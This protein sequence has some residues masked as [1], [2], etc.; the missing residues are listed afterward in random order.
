MLLRRREPDAE[1]EALLDRIAA[2]VSE[3]DGNSPGGAHLGPR[4]FL[5]L[6][7]TYADEERLV[8][9][10]TAMELLRRAT[11]VHRMPQL[12]GSLPPFHAVQISQTLAGDTLL[13]ASFRILAADGDARIVQILSHAMATVSEGELERGASYLLDGAFRRAAF[14]EG[15]ARAGAHLA[16]MNE[17]ETQRL[18]DWAREIGKAHEL[19]LAGVTP[20]LEALRSTAPDEIIPGDGCV[21]ESV[22]AGV[23]QPDIVRCVPV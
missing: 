22:L 19:A 5:F 7:K 23:G 3:Y 2:N 8:R 6:A 21:W 11:L 20:N 10:A 1:C 15:A 4:L 9:L 17:A 12:Y 14:A 13:A 16:G 18:A